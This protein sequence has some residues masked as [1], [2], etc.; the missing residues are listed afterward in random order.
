MANTS[1]AMRSHGTAPTAGK[2]TS[3]AKASGAQSARPA[4][5]ASFGRNFGTAQTQQAAQAATTTQA[6]AKPGGPGLL[7]T[8]VQFLLAETRT[9]EAT[10]GFAAPS[11]LGRA[12]DAYQRVQKRVRETINASIHAASS[13]LGLSEASHSSSG[14]AAYATAAAA[15]QDSGALD[16]DIGGE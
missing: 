8:G 9:Q 15:Y 7:S 3:A 4:D 1:L 13:D 10:A 11:N 12:R 2:P 16:D 5:G 6:F 14:H